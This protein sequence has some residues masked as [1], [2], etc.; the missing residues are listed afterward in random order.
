M[1]PVCQQ[2][3]MAIHPSLL[4]GKWLFVASTRVAVFDVGGCTRER[5]GFRTRGILGRAWRVLPQAT[6]QGTRSFGRT[7]DVPLRH[8]CW[9]DGVLCIFL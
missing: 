3:R 7:R 5:F 9:D 6:R 1:P 2:S 8:R 4:L